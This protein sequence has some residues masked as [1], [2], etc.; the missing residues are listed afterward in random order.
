[1]VGHEYEGPGHGGREA[2]HDQAFKDELAASIVM[3]EQK[4]MFWMHQK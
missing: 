1:M 4:A 2:S 3:K